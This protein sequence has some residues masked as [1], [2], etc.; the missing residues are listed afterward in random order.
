[1]DLFDACVCANVCGV[2]V[3]IPDVAQQ[4]TAHIKMKTIL[5]MMGVSRTHD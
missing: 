4:C 2:C 5:A 3:C 1:M